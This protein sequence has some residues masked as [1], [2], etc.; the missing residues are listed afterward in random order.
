L[1]DESDWNRDA[2]IGIMK[3]QTKLKK[4]KCYDEIE[5]LQVLCLLS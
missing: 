5:E 2:K 3:S 1:D 4:W